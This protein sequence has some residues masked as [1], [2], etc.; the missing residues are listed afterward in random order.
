M[1]GALTSFSFAIGDIDGDGVDDDVDNCPSDYNPDQLDSDNDSDGEVCD[2]C[3]DD[4]TDTCDPDS[5]A[6]A[7]VSAVDGA[8][9]TT[10]NGHASF[11]VPSGALSADSS[12]SITQ[13]TPSEPNVRIED[14]QGIIVNQY[15]F[16]PTGAIFNAPVTIT[17]EAECTST[18][19]TLT[20]IWVYDDQTETWEALATTA[21]QIGGGI[22]E[23]SATTTHFTLFALVR[24]PD[25]DNDGAPDNWYGEEDECQDSNLSETVV[26]DGC[27]S[28]AE[29]IL[30][31]NGCTISDLIEELR[32]DARN[33]GQFVTRVAELTREL[34]RDGVITHREKGKIRRCAALGRF[35]YFTRIP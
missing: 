28:E 4:A 3:P 32:T 19:C 22:Y 5:S 17:V 15:S 12:M 14:S 34:K 2:F 31:A 27:D 6:N 13:T 35:K 24:P 33:H 11:N 29:N 7:Y 8:T 18:F 30:T 25:S 26:I 10:P 20:Q 9:L 23:Y 1:H 21:Q 16:T